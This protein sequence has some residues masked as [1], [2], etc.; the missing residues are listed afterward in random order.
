[1]GE[2]KVPA[3]GWQDDIT[4]IISDPEEEDKYVEIMEKKSK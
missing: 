3:I 1:M 2:M 4:A